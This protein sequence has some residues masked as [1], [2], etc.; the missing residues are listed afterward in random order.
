MV[1]HKKEKVFQC[2]EAVSSEPC[3]LRKG[4]WGSCDNRD[5]KVAE[6]IWI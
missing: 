3:G 1:N 6:K 2:L 5:W 4:I